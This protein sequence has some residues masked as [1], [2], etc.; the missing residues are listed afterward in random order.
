MSEIVRKDIENISKLFIKTVVEIL[1]DIRIY[2]T[3]SEFSKD[4]KIFVNGFDIVLQIPAHYLYVDKGRK[5]GSKRPP[6]SEIYKWIKKSEIAIPKDFDIKS[7]AFAISNSIASKGIKARPFIQD[8]QDA[9]AILTRD[10]IV[11][12]INKNNKNAK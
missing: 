3:E 9:I 8:L 2:K 12:L 5:K 4:F 1:N 7:F 11:G 6:V 10:Y